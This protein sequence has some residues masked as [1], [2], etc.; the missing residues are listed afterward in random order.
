MPSPTFYFVTIA[1]IISLLFYNK[2]KNTK[3]VY[4]TYF[5]VFTFIIE[6]LGYIYAKVLLINTNPIYN[7]YIILTCLFYILFY[8]SLFKN[9]TNKKIMNAFVII[10]LLFTIFDFVILK[11]HFINDFLSNN[12]VFGP[13]L[14]A[15]ILILFLI[16][17]I[18]NEAVIFNI[19]K[20]FIFWVSVGALLFYIG[21]IP[22]II[23]SEL[24][25]F[26][27]LYDNILSGLNFIMYGSFSL[28][29]ILSDK[30]YNY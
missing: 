7:T 21:V 27:G 30:K 26:D 17:I 13:I 2:F 18:N 20:T 23:T 11:S 12:F 10:Y 9:K 24:L 6:L 8:K 15:L 25:N 28:G 14:I 16:E 19:K 3:Y 1:F 22:I 29:Y 5:L 4:F